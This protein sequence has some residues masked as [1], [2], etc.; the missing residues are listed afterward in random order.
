MDFVCCICD[1][2]TSLFMFI[3]NILTDN[4]MKVIELGLTAWGCYIAYKA[5]STWRQQVIEQPKIELAREI[6]EQFYNMQDLIKRARDPLLTIDIENIKKHCQLPDDVDSYRCLYLTPYCQ[7]QIDFEIVIKFQN[8]KNKTKIFFN[9]NLQQ[10]FND[11]IDIVYQIRNNSRI[12]YSLSNKNCLM[13]M[14]K[15]VKEKLNEIKEQNTEYK[16]DEIN[17]KISQILNEVEYN[18]KPIYETKAIK[19]KKLNQEPKEQE[20]DK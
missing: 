6:V 12:L 10:C 18:L 2:I 15:D 11:M 16:D 5:L 7:I 8:L 14:A 3:W 17:Q 1:K 13:T 19:W 20:N 4:D 9:N